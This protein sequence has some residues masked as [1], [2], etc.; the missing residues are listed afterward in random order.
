MTNSKGNTFYC[1][2]KAI[3][4]K[5]KKQRAG[6]RNKVALTAYFIW[7]IL[8]YDYNT[9]NSKVSTHYHRYNTTILS[10]EKIIVGVRMSILRM[11]QPIMSVL[12]S[13]VNI[14][15]QIINLRQHIFMVTDQVVDN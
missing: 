6:E 2:S 13:V 4:L 14:A 3:N 12:D 5:G 10:I 11:T 8:N 7:L 9:A 1:R 15:N